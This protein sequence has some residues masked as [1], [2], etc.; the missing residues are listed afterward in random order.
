MDV[1][2]STYEPATQTLTAIVYLCHLA[3]GGSILQVDCRRSTLE[4]Y[5]IAVRTYGL[6]PEN[7]ARDILLDPDPSRTFPL[8]MFLSV[9]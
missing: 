2:L 9:H 8:L 6:L 1:S 7:A 4:G 3:D 5:M